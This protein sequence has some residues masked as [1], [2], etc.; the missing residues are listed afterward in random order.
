MSGT[1]KVNPS[2]AGLGKLC[3]LPGLFPHLCRAHHHS[4]NL[5]EMV[6][7]SEHMNWRA[8]RGAV[9][10]LKQ[11][12]TAVTYS[13]TAHPCSSLPCCPA[14]VGTWSAAGSGDP[15]WGRGSPWVAFLWETSLCLSLDTTEAQTGPGSEWFCH[16]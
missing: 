10:C 8:L 7:E 1:L 14:G 4:A 9:C 2:S 6:W 11:G 3:P 5:K 12:L 13:R 16:G 15:R